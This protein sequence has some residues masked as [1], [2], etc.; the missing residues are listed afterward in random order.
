MVDCPA[1]GRSLRVPSEDGGKARAEMLQRPTGDAKFLSALEELSSLG[2]PAKPAPA[3]AAAR[4]NPAPSLPTG[5]RRGSDRPSGDVRDSMRIVP[6]SQAKTRAEEVLGE[7]S[8]LLPADQPEPLVIPEILP[9]EDE[10]T[11]ETNPED[12]ETP[13]ILANEVATEE[14]TSVLSELAGEPQQEL[15]RP[16]RSA[17]ARMQSLLLVTVAVVAFVGGL[18]TSRSFGV[19]GTPPVTG[20]TSEATAS[21]QGA[22]HQE[23]APEIPAAEP[24]DAGAAAVRGV[25]TFADESGAVQPD[26]EAIVLLLPVRNLSGL[27]LDAGPLRERTPTAARTAIEAALKVLNVTYVRADSRGQYQLP[28]LSQDPVLLLVISRHA[29]RPEGEPLPAAVADELQKWFESQ[30]R[31]TGR[32]AVHLQ[33]LAASSAENAETVNVSFSQ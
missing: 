29:A 17:G 24:A 15:A 22:S 31:I 3:P 12:S 26:S 18:L 32:L 19:F 25:V 30:E 10:A 11:E 13:R 7:L 9:P 21:K 5:A 16:T 6:L 33:S 4:R 8:G 20:T 28:R 1:C 23:R 27:K 2:A 14:W